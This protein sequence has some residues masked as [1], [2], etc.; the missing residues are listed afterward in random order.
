MYLP[1]PFPTCGRPVPLKPV[2]G[3]WPV[4]VR[5]RPSEAA[6]NPGAA[7]LNICFF[8]SDVLYPESIRQKR[9]IFNPT[10]FK[11]QQNMLYISSQ[12]VSTSQTKRNLELWSH[13]SPTDGC[14]KTGIGSTRK[15]AWRGCFSWLVVA[16][17]SLWRGGGRGA[18]QCP[19]PSWL[20]ESRVEAEPP[21]FLQAPPRSL[22]RL[23]SGSPS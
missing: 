4:A 5:G 21:G 9:L 6:H 14:K 15:D 11:Q 10:L 18:L 12:T 16:S 20:S 19:F 17:V 23:G 7:S 8:P 2:A 3:A 22:H 13:S 1:A